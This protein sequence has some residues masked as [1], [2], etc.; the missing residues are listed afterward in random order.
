M[1][2]KAAHKSLLVAA[3]LLAVLSGYSVYAQMNS[4]HSGPVMNYHRVND[5]LVTGGHLLDGGTAALKEQGVKVVIDLRDESPSGEKERLAEQGIKW[6]NIPVEW[7]DPQKWR[8]AR[9][10][11]HAEACGCYGVGNIFMSWKPSNRARPIHGLWHNTPS[12]QGPRPQS[13]RD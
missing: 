11:S 7:N 9:L 13:N 1:L 3:G 2:K 6:I 8:G 4:E 10:S 12:S 5:R